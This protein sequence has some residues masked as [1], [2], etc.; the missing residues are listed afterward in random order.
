MAA[1]AGRA[2]ERGARAGGGGWEGKGGR[3]DP[4]RGE[5][6]RAAPG[7]RPRCRRPSRRTDARGFW[8]PGARG[9]CTSWSRGSRG[10]RG[11]N[12]PLPPHLPG[13]GALAAGGERGGDRLRGPPHPRRPPAAQL[14]PATPGPGS[15]VGTA[16]GSR[17]RGVIPASHSRGTAGRGAVTHLGTR[18]SGSTCCRSA[19]R[20]SPGPPGRARGWCSP[21]GASSP[22]DPRSSASSCST[23]PRARNP[24]PEGTRAPSS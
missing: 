22:P 4:S 23:D 7:S 15:V 18:G 12:P 14:S 13:S 8:W 17:E 3:T 24:R 6:C 20:R 1:P 21:S 11:R 10:T 9:A 16:A 5:G 2:T 19:A